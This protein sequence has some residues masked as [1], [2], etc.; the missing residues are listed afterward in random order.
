MT[1]K[2][3]KQFIISGHVQGVWFRATTHEQAKTLGITGWAKNLNNGDVEV[4]ACGTEQQLEILHEWLHHG[5]QHA[6]VEKVV[7]TKIDWCEF[8]QFTVK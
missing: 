5:P 1:Q 3:C 6:R 7:S 8:D 4:I 2:I